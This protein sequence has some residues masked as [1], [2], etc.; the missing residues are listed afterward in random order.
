MPVNRG[1]VSAWAVCD[2]AG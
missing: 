1:A 2:T